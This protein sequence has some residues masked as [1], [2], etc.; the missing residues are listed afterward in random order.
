MIGTVL[1]SGLV[2]LGSSERAVVILSVTMKQ[3]QHGSKYSCGH[4]GRDN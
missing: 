2:G 3:P 1:G 4:E